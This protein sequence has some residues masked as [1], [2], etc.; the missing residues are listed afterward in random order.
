MAP[1]P[2]LQTFLH[3]I[4]AN[5]RRLRIARGWT[6]KELAKATGRHERHIQF[7]ETGKQNPTVKILVAVADALGVA[8]T[9]LFAPPV[10]VSDDNAPKRTRPAKK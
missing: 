6:Q 4:G 5:V 10:A 3:Y 2:R 8:P 7:L 9:D 1:S